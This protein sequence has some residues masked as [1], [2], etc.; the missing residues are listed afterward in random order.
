MSKY[1][2][3]FPYGLTGFAV[4]VFVFYLSVGKTFA[5]EGMKGW[6]IDSPYNQLY[7]ASEMDAFKGTVRAFKEIVPL[8]GMSPGVGVVVRDRDGE[9]ILVHLCPIAYRA[10]SEI[11]VKKGDR[12][13]LKGVWVEIDGQDVFM[14]SKIKRGDYFEFKVRL[15]KNGKP[16]WTMTPEELAKE[17]VTR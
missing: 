12:V 14:A 1:N 3:P 8:K 5:T 17:G 15:T 10:E 4:L 7:D 13:K 9:D 2:R 6:E 11:G 16:F